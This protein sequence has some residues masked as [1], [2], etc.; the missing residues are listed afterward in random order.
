[1]LLNVDRLQFDRLFT[2]R[3]HGDRKAQFLEVRVYSNC[4]TVELLLHGRSLGERQSAPSER[5]LADLAQ[6]MTTFPSGGRRP[7]SLISTAFGDLC[8]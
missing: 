4:D 7:T 5:V 6:L 2:V 3:L 8:P 1:M